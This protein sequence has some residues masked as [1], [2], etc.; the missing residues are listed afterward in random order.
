MAKIEIF[1]DDAFTV[2]T[3]TASINEQPYVPGRLA[4]LGLFEEEGISTLTAQIEYDGEQ[5]GL[6]AT[7]PRGGTA[8]PTT[9]SGRRLIP[10]NT[11]HLPQRSTMFADEIQGI[12]AFGSQTELEVAQSRV[13]KY[14]GKHRAQLDFTHEY[15]RIG[16]INGKVLDADGTSVL[17]DVY[18]TFGI[19]KKVISM[20]LTVANTN[21]RAKCDDV[22]DEIE[23]ALGAIPLR[24]GRAL[25]G[26]E[27]WSQLISHKSVRETYLNTA[28]AAE[29]RGKTPDTFDFGGIVW[30]RYR[31]SING[32][33][34]IPDT[35]ARAF[36]DGVPSL[37]MTR[38]SPADYMET[39]NTDGLPYY[40]KVEPLRFGKGLEIESQSNPLH[41]PTRPKTIIHLTAN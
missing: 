1:E 22:L 15:H 10:V 29:L 41:I 5:I 11:V 13:N 21:A 40:S 4:E 39:V 36:P 26:K 30:E 27:F 31:G 34:F 28:Q 12:R 37:F 6:V 14:L 7:K 18:A 3:L 24:G 35:E 17:L 8:D 32:V 19:E 16:A 33:P 9:L 38:F 20:A 2:E 23:K 25:C